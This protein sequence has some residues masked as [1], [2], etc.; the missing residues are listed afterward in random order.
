MKA[1]TRAVLV[2][3]LVSAASFA[4]ESKKLESNVQK[5]SYAIGLQLGDNLK[6]QGILDLDEEA[7]ALGIRDYL[8]GNDLKLTPDE[9]QQAV[10]AY[11]QEMM[12]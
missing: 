2:L 10:A 3:A 1:V 9:V 6:K 11:Q 8:D 12:E 4:D 7:V 5:F